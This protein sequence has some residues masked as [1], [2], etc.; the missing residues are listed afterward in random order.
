MESTA[1]PEPPATG[2]LTF[3]VLSGKICV[4]DPR[5]ERG[6]EGG[7][8]ELPATNGIWEA[9]VTVLDGE[10]FGAIVGSLTVRW[11]ES[12]PQE[13][14]PPGGRPDIA[15]RPGGECRTLQLLVDSGQAGVFDAAI[16]PEAATGDWSDPQSFY[17]KACDLT[18]SPSQGGI[19]DGRGVVFRSG[20]GDGEYNGHVTVDATGRAFEVVIIFD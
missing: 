1:A 2:R 12:A 8:F 7:L 20:L 10:G 18:L 4:T 11:V 13:L 5:L 16:Y 14:D 19:L 17:G 3:Q 6:R 9:A 15:G